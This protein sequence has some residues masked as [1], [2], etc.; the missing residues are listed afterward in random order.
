MHDTVVSCVFDDREKCNKYIQYFSKC[1]KIILDFSNGLFVCLKTL[2]NCQ[3][4]CLKSI[5]MINNIK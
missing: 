4:M 3:K 1:Q 2:K 5:K